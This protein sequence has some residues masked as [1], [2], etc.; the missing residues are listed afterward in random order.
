MK[1]KKIFGDTVKKRKKRKI[2]EFL[3]EC[4]RKSQ[5]QKNVKNISEKNVMKLIK[6]LRKWKKFY[7]NFGEKTKKFKK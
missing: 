7:E 3:R 6:N 4:K 5:F 1:G 2:P